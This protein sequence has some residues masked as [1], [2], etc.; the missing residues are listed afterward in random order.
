MHFCPYSS[1]DA[2]KWIQRLEYAGRSLSPPSLLS[3]FLSPY[4]SLS[5]SLTHSLSLLFPVIF[6]LLFI[7]LLDPHTIL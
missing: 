5:L 1:A 7:F 2:F 6:T 3:L 4:L